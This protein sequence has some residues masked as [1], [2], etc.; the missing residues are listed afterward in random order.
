[1]LIRYSPDDVCCSI[2]VCS[3]ANPFCNVNATSDV[4]SIG[5]RFVVNEYDTFEMQCGVAYA[6]FLPPTIQCRPQA[7]SHSVNA[8]TY[9]VY[10]TQRIHALYN[11]SGTTFHCAVTFR[12]R[13]AGNSHIGCTQSIVAVNTPSFNHKVASFIIT[14]LRK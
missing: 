2:C 11:M 6:G 7:A 4:G 14:V 12:E 13:T 3:T 5:D 10:Y 1:M 8:T 9:G